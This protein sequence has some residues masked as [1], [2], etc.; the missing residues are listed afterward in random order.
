[1]LFHIAAAVVLTNIAFMEIYS[2][3]E[4]ADNIS[5]NKLLS[6]E[7]SK[8]SVQL[9]LAPSLRKA[10]KLVNRYRQRLEFPK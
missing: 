6:D 5:D 1:M 9:L 3:Y 2:F 10:L 8:L 7:G 4:L